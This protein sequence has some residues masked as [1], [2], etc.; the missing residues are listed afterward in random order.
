MGWTIPSPWAVEPL[1]ATRLVST[2]SR[3][4]GL[5]RDCHRLSTEGF[6]EF[7]RCALKRFRLSGQVYQGRA[8]PLSYGGALFDFVGQSS[9]RNRCLFWFFATPWATPGS[10][11]ISYLIVITR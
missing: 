1:G 2:P 6:P 4:A 7:G 8:L 11:R 5:A 9:L 10:T 3:V